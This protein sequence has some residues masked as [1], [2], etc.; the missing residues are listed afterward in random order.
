MVHLE[1]EVRDKM[2][3][4]QIQ[5]TKETLLETSHLTL[6]T[7][8]MNKS[9]FALR[10]IPVICFQNICHAKNMSFLFLN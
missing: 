7:L 10:Q 1:G 6:E 2:I 9:S 8:I 5:P 4:G 3:F